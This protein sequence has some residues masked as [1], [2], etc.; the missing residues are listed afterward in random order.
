MECASSEVE[1]RGSSDDTGASCVASIDASGN[2]TYVCSSDSAID[3]VGGANHGTV[4]DG[5]VVHSC[6]DSTNK[7]V[8]NCSRVFYSDV[9]KCE[10]LYQTVI[11]GFE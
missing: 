4:I 5:L 11:K 6:T 9:L 8:G 1:R 10:P 2:T 3:V 7:K